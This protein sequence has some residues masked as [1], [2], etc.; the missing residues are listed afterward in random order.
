MSTA[1]KA[2]LGILASVVVG[3]FVV[4]VWMLILRGPG[5]VHDSAG[6]SPSVSE[7]ATTDDGGETGEESE[8]PT[9]E[10]PEPSASPSASPS[11]EL[12]AVPVDA[13]VLTSFALP[14]RNIACTMSEQAVVCEIANATFTPPAGDACEWRGQ[15]VVLD[16]DGVSM[17]CP[18]GAPGTAPEGT[19]VLEY[20]QTSAVGTWLCTSS[21]RGVECSSRADGTGFTLA[22]AGFSSY[23]PGR[24]L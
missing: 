13:V 2:T 24:L 9:Q 22:R 8:S 16:D 15:V 3:L 14:S 23:G 21:E 5:G 19:V 11:Q 1:I 20:G 4:L 10:E 18:Q 17:P 12:S 7:D 6:A